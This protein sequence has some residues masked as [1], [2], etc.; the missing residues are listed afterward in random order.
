MTMLQ[1]N[2]EAELAEVVKGATTPLSIQGGATRGLGVT[3]IAGDT[4]SVA[5]LSGIELYEPGALTLVV[6]A[7]TP[8]AHIESQLASEGQ[9]L[10][11]EPIDHRA[12]LGSSGTPTIG[13]VVAANIS[14]PR[15]I[16]VGAARDFALGI[17]FVDGRGDVVR[18][19]GRV[20]KNV[21]GYDLVKLIS[22]SF[23]TLGVITEVA[24]KV[25]P[26]SET[27]A[28][29]QVAVSNPDEAISV[30]ST[31]LNSPYDVS[32]AAYDPKSGCA[33]LRIEG[34]EDQVS[35]RAAQLHSLLSPLGD[36]ST[37]A[38]DATTDLWRA[39]ANVTEFADRAGDVWRVSCAPSA[40]PKLAALA[41]ADGLLFDWA[42]GLI[43][44]LMPAGTDLRGRLGKYSGHATLV[45]G[46]AAMGRFEPKLRPLAALDKGLRAQFDPNGI[47]NQGLMA[48]AEA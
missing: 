19:G 48:A 24:L 40:A 23:G 8:V 38:A 31:A 2:S 18:N 21:T 3:G 5:G 17:R 46:D 33:S 37:L 44:M 26:I 20:M 25:L 35:Y 14:G 39:I 30:M 4:L 27:Q 11:F 32:G 28:S 43:W 7:G 47:F 16:Q 45:R 42:G 6:Q 13:G 36:V 41:E 22:G 10:A 29:L 15:R 34:F 12:L 9:R 1:P